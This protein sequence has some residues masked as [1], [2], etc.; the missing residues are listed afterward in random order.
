MSH[1]GTRKIMVLYV[2]CLYLPAIFD[3][4]V[5]R[6]LLGGQKVRKIFKLAKTNLKNMSEVM[7]SHRRSNIRVYWQ[8]IC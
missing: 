3:F 4:C 2:L 7:L 1:S 5:V 8:Y 6:K